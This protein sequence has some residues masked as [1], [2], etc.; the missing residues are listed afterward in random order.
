VALAIW[1]APVASERVH[2]CPLYVNSTPRGGIVNQ[3]AYTLRH[4]PQPV[5]L[6]VD[7]S[8]LITAAA[9]IITPTSATGNLSRG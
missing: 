6:A 1:T 4:S 9:S 5:H 7:A 3:R 2:A 8:R